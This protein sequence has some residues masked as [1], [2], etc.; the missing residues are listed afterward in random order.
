[1]DLMKKIEDARKQVGKME[2]EGVFKDEHINTVKKNLQGD[3]LRAYK[4]DQEVKAWRLEKEQNDIIRKYNPKASIQDPEK[5][6]GSTMTAE[7]KYSHLNPEWR[8]L[9]I[10]IDQGKGIYAYDLLGNPIKGEPAESEGNNPYE[11]VS[12]VNQAE[13]SHDMLKLKRFETE[14][15]AARTSDLEKKVEQ[16]HKSRSGDVEEL[17]VIAVELRNRGEHEKA[18]SL[19]DAVDGYNLREPWLND[20]RFKELEKEKSKH[21]TYSK[22]DDMLFL[23]DDGDRYISA[24]EIF[25]NGDNEKGE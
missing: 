13:S 11:K 12:E 8:R 1:M 22:I 23:D 6:K 19:M 7:E 2:K 10:E 21:Q 3:I 16:V 9:Q 17:N 24:S 14:Y 15:R 18:D 5:P 20:S 25:K 4:E